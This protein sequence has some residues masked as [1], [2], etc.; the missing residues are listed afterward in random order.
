MEK[1]REKFYLGRGAIKSRRSARPEAQA[2]VVPVT[3]QAER[4]AHAPPTMS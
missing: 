1:A 4:R 3:E 2:I